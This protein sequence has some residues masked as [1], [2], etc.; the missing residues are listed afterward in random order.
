MINYICEYIVTT[1]MQQQA[2]KPRSVRK[3]R[4]TQAD[5]EPQTGT[6]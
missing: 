5:S 3:N 2:R 4:L 1:E 6:N